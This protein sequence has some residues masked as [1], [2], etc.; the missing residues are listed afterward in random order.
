MLPRLPYDAIFAVQ[1]EMLSCRGRPSRLPGLVEARSG[2]LS[3]SPLLLKCVAGQ[4]GPPEAC[5]GLEPEHGSN[6]HNSRVDEGEVHLHLG[7]FHLFSK[8]YFSGRL[9]GSQRLIAIVEQSKMPCTS[10]FF[11]FFFSQTKSL[12]ES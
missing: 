12:L 3:A 8:H 5:V 11:C 4:D 9:H 2:F 10:L 6:K 7:F 1:L